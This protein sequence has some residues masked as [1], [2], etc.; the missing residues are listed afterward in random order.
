M[1]K[2]ARLLIATAVIAGAAWA[3]IALHPAPER[4]IRNR[5]AKLAAIASIQP[6][7]NEITRGYHAL[8]IL[9]YFTQDAV[10]SLNPWRADG[11]TLSGKEDLRNMS[12]A[13]SRLASLKIQFFD[14]TVTLAPDRQSATVNLVAAVTL[15]SDRDPAPQP[16]LIKMRKVQGQ[17]LI[18]EVT[19]LKVL[20]AVTLAPAA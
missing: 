4:V 6:G 13:A 17:W 16:L 11:G 8:A 18:S 19:A 1:Q 2:I 10:L 14:V 7:E 20:G 3:W 12:T 9:D 15:P 5:L